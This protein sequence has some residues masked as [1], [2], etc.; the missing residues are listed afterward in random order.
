MNLSEALLAKAINIGRMGQHKEAIAA[1]DALIS[2][3]IGDN[4]AENQLPIAQAYFN[5][6]TSLGELGCFE[7][8]LVCYDNLTSL[9]KRTNHLAV[10]Q[11]VAQG[12]FNKAITLLQLEQNE[13]AL[14]VFK[15][16]NYLFQ[17]NNDGD[18]QTVKIQASINQ[19]ILLVQLG[20]ADEALLLADKLILDFRDSIIEDVQALLI[21]F[22]TTMIEFSLL[23]DTIEQTL[24]RIE[25]VNTILDNSTFAQS[26]CMA[27]AISVA[28]ISFYRFSLKA[29]SLDEVLAVIAKIPSNNDFD[30][31]FD[32]LTNYLS[33]FTGGFG[34]QIKQL[35]D[36]FEQ[37]HNIEQL[38]T[39][40]TECYSD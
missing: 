5:K 24:G 34:T 35:V 1:Y 11:Q 14:A 10:Q 22:T 7:E 18:I 33:N 23:N 31:S 26:N 30:C 28:L 16:L 27:Q 38:T 20:K 40:L 17:N 37:H 13:Q 12:Y 19:T 21:E 3:F 36:Y 32:D 25:A 6:A 39:A 2:M 4:E 15:E 29:C 8:E 9:F